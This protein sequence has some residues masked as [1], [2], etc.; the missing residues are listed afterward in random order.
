MG[1]SVKERLDET[2]KRDKREI[3]EED[4]NMKPKENK[5]TNVEDFM[6]KKIKEM[7]GD[8][9]QKLKEDNESDDFE[10][11]FQEE[12]EEKSSNVKKV[13]VILLVLIISLSTILVLWSN[14]YE[15]VNFAFDK[16]SEINEEKNSEKKNEVVESEG[17]AQ[18]TMD[19]TQCYQTVHHMANTI[20]IADDGQIWGQNEITREAVTQ[21]VNELKGRDDYLSDELK[22]WLELDFSNGVEVH[23]Y[24]WDKLDGNIGKAKDLNQEKIQQVIKDMTE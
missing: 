15:I 19:L 9:E 20:I 13:I 3:N 17:A 1:K 24:V 18:A 8:D 11:D 5:E 6:N 2:I 7:I 14:G 22:K 21:M 4:N 16:V 12:F 10:E 23:N